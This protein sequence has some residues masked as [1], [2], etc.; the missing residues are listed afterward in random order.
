MVSS[1]CSTSG[2][3]GAKFVTNKRQ[4]I[5]RGQYKMVYP[6]KLATQGTQ[7]EIKQNKNTTHYVLDSATRR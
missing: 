4:R 6:E 1:L 2:I 5:Q 3:H 7:D